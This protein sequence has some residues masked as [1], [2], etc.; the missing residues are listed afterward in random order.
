MSTVKAINFSHPSRQNPNITLDIGGNLSTN[1]VTCNVMSVNSITANVSASSVKIRNV[2]VLAKCGYNGFLML[3]NGV[4]YTCAANQGSW[5]SY[6]LGRGNSYPNNMG[7]D[8]M[9]SVN[10]PGE[11]NTSS[12]IIDANTNSYNFAYALFSNGN[13]YTWGNN[14]SGE[15]GVGSTSRLEVPTLSATNVTN[16]YIHPSNGDYAISCKA[17]IRKADGY[18]YVAGYNGNGQL[19]VGDTTNRTSW[20]QLTSLGTN[21]LSVWNMGSDYGCIVVQKGDYTIW[22]AGYNGYGQLGVGDTTNRTSFVNASSAWGITGS[23]TLTKVTGGF[24]YYSSGG[25]SATWMGMLLSNGTFRTCGYAGDYSLG[26]ASTSNISTPYK[27]SPG[28]TDNIS[29]VASHG[30]GL[31]AVWALKSDGTMWGWG[32][33]DYG[34]CGDGT[35]SYVTSPKVIST[36]VLQLMSD[37]MTQY[38]QGYVSQGFVRK[39][40]GLYCTGY[41]GYGHLG[42]GDTTSRSSLTRVALPS[43]F[44]VSNMGWYSSTYPLRSIIAVSTD[45]RLYAWGYNGQYNISGEGYANYVCTPIPIRLPLGG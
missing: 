4:V 1:T 5:S 13:L 10:F 7:Y 28:G 15:C 9:R 27:V 2:S 17:I 32:R 40:D 3:Q 41:N 12:Y 23:Q 16:V 6:T 43:D 19:G 26:N 33:N 42:V 8:S 38:I 20:T 24:G 25:G 11:T 29:D 31:A 44:V 30:G 45:G 21:I 36:G 39:S 35:T 34:Q 14:G 37:C 22:V 18:L